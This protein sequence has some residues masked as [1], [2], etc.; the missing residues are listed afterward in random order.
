M[1]SKNGSLLT[2]FTS[3]LRERGSADAPEND[4]AESVADAAEL[5][6][7][8]QR[9]RQNDAIRSQE[10]KSLRQ[11]IQTHG[12]DHAPGTPPA[13]SLAHAARSPH[14]AADP[15]REDSS[16]QVTQWWGGE[17]ATT[18]DPLATRAAP[19]GTPVDNGDLDLDLDFTSMLA[20]A[21][22]PALTPAS[23]AP[24]PIPTP[25]TAATPA[26]VAS[27]T[28]IGTAP[29]PAA[30]AQPA[31]ASRAP[32]TA[33]LN[34]TEI[35]LRKAA[36]SFSAGEYAAAQAHLQAALVLP[37]LRQEE[38]EMLTFALL[39]IYRATGQHERFDAAALDYAERN[40]RS[41]A[42]WFSLPEQLALQRPAS[43]TPS[44][45]PSPATAAVATAVATAW[46]CPPQLDARTLVRLQ[47]LADDTTQTCAIDWKQLCDIE[48]S[49]GA[50]LRKIFRSWCTSP[51]RLQWQHADALLQA[52]AMH[53]NQ[54]AQH[55]DELWWHLHMDCLCILGR[56]EEFEDLSLEYCVAF[57]LS[58]PSWTEVKC[59]LTQ[60]GPAAPYAHAAASATEHSGEAPLQ[61][62][63]ANCALVGDVCGEHSPALRVLHAAAQSE[64]I[65]V[66]C[67]LLR[68]ID[69]AATKELLAWCRAATERGA[70]I[71]FVQM[72]RLVL[73]FMLIKGIDQYAQL[74]TR[75]N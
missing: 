62:A 10:F 52:L 72:P 53:T 42:E 20:T 23:K 26:A 35:W 41:P 19:V 34:D 57:E 49:T 58:P 60:P 8:L 47:A 22:E 37:D 73:L 11:M 45:P 24:I 13:T 46:Q 1:E 36:I 27:S 51:V 33:Q 29:A 74:S 54:A 9:R 18:P 32:G 48:A 50:A 15:Q 43:A 66:S 4:A 25:L 6:K 14:P 65:T 56:K 28:V 3:F 5:R 17:G 30:S 59:Q 71:R 70:L 44:Q 21:P 75:A 12:P 55:A 61:G 38:V 67:A 39:D 63:F 31:T 64:V 2:K 40:G 69:F 16:P 7:Q 68:R